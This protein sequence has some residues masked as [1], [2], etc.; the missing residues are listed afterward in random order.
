MSG[1]ERPNDREFATTLARGLEILR[2]FKP[3]EPT[4]SNGE[5]ARRTGLSK[6]TITRFTYTL[7]RLGYLK[8]E[9]RTAHYRL[10]SAVLS[11][12]YPMLATI[13]AR[14]IARPAM[15]ELAEYAQGSVSM[16][17]RD[18]LDIVYVETSRSR[19]VFSS[20]MADIG[21]SH[22]MIGSAIGRAYLCACT[23]EERLALLNEI[24][25]KT[26]D[27]WARHEAAVERSLAAF[28]QLRFC[29]SYGDLRPGTHAVAVPLRRNPNAEIIVVNCVVQAFQLKEGQLE[30]DLGPRLAALARAMEFSVT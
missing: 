20:R 11:L 3:D 19:S 27:Q 22:P 4:L 10:G 13:A 25:V 28:G 17:I 29:V 9:A 18:R 6:A 5:L 1:V 2:C 23:P 24:R 16:G 21:M 30:N 7:V 12:G 14:Q 26:P 15:S 8:Q